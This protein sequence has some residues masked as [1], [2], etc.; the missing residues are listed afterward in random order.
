MSVESSHDHR[1]RPDGRPSRTNPPDRSRKP[2]FL[3]FFALR[4]AG[5]RRPVAWRR[6]G[7]GR[8]SRGGRRGERRL[9]R[10]S[11]RPVRRRHPGPHPRPGSVVHVAHAICSRRPWPWPALHPDRVIYAEAGSEKAILACFEEGLRHGGLAGVVAEVARLPMTPSRRL[12]LA[13]EVHRHHRHRH[14]PMAKTDRGRGFRTADGQHDPLAGDGPALVT[15]A[16][17]RGGTAAMAGG[18][19]PG[20]CRGMRGF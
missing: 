1:P 13:A 12:Q 16:G 2:G 15:T 19:D 7:L 6:A 9:G 3:R 17:A 20:A 10:G 5:N 11:G 18:V 14:P 8:S 4:R